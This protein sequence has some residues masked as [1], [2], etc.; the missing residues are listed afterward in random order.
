MILQTKVV[1]DWEAIKQL[2]RSSTIKSNE[3][4]NKTR[5]HHTYRPGDQILILLR[6]NDEKIGKMQQPTE[7]PYT[8][9]RVYRRGLLK[10]LRG[11]YEENIHIRRVKPF[12]NAAWSEN[13]VNYDITWCLDHG[14]A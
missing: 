7:G 6:S 2:K 12:Y 10:I 8:V 4:E 1:A 13:N 5:L 14:G 9:L 11:N 3:Q